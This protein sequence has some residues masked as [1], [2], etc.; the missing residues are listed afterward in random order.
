MKMF[1]W[2]LFPALIVSALLG[3]VVQAQ[4]CYQ[5]CRNFQ[6]TGGKITYYCYLTSSKVSNCFPADKTWCDP[7]NNAVPWSQNPTGGSCTT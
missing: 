2:L 3:S 1:C 4:K 5:G 7:Q 6:F